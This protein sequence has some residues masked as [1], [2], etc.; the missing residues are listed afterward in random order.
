MKKKSFVILLLMMLCLSSCKSEVKEYRMEGIS[1]LEK[2]DA[3]K[4]LPMKSGSPYRKT[5]W[6]FPAVVRPGGKKP[7]RKAFGTL[8]QKNFIV[9]LYKRG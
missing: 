5:V 9:F 4:F 2:G 8:C 6:C 3:E 7:N 1:A